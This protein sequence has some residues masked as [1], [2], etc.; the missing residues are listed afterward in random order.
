MGLIF[1]RGINEVHSHVTRFCDSNYAC[2]LDH[3]RSLTGYIFTLV[4]N[5]IRWRVTLLSIVALLT[6][7]AEYMTATEA[8]K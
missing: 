1:G 2:D 4:G 6:I 5:A 8:V 3:K 7:E